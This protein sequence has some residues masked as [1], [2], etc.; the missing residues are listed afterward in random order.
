MYAKKLQLLI[1]LL[2]YIF[3][4]YSYAELNVQVFPGFGAYQK[5][6][7]W[8]ALNVILSNEGDELECVI[9]VYIQDKKVYSVP[10]ALHKKSRKSVNL[11]VPPQKFYRNATI[12]IDDISGKNILKKDISINKISERDKLIIVIEQ[13]DN[14]PVFPIN[15]NVANRDSEK[16]SS[17]L[18]TDTENIYVS[19]STVGLLPICWKGYDSVDIVVIGNISA[20]EFS[21]DQRIALVDWVCGGGTLVVSGGSNSHNIKGTFVEKLLPV[22]LGNIQVLK[23]LDSLS[24]QFGYDIN[25]FTSVIIASSELTDG[26]KTIVTADNDEI[27]IAEKSIGSGR[28]V[29]LAYNY[30]DPAFRSWKGN[31]FLLDKILPNK[32][33]Q[34]PDISNDLK[35]LFSINVLPV[36][37]SHRSI[38][39]FLLIYVICFS[40]AFIFSR[41][42]KLS[43]LVTPIIIVLFIIGS[44]GFNYAKEKR[45]IILNDFSIIEIFTNYK[46]LKINSYFTL[47]SPK[48]SKFV[49]RLPNEQYF[50]VNQV[51]P[52]DMQNYDLTSKE[53]DVYQVEIST[54]QN[55]EQGIFHGE[56]YSNLDERTSIYLNGKKLRNNLPYDINNC[57]VFDNGY[58]DHIGSFKS[59]TEI[60]FGTDIPYADDIIDKLHSGEEN[61]RRFINILYKYLDINSEKRMLIGWIDNSALHSFA[62]IDM[63]ESYK[64]HG[65]TLAIIYF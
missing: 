20:A 56:M 34:R 40:S 21:Q 26:G 39:L 19:Y 24:K 23:S 53:N 42:G 55:T 13:D 59:G 38:G 15:T 64:S 4:N 11:Y 49:I 57:Y 33:V 37:A 32:V 8:L 63:G 36:F 43:Y 28:C 18:N 5:N 2:F 44:I 58:Y 6:N 10:V 45:K 30:L 48:I 27:I 51:F 47:L 35:K 12:V 1:I 17:D 25:V 9:S 52:K 31:R 7:H 54:P 22:K 60:V 14:V 46:R 61:K 50:F 16:F 41:R 62:K 3:L 29:F 65:M